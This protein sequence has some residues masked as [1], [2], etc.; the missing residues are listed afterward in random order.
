V[1][2]NEGIAPGGGVQGRLM[3]VFIA[4]CLAVLVYFHPSL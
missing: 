2:V 3:V 1:L 4:F